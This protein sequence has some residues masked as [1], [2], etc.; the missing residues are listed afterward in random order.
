MKADHIIIPFKCKT[1]FSIQASTNY[2]VF[3][4]RNETIIAEHRKYEG[5]IILCVHLE[6]LNAFKDSI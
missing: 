1:Q 5:V 6:E 4:V 3:E 2:G